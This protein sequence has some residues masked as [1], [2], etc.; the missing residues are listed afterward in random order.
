MGEGEPS[1]AMSGSVEELA[2]L[3]RGLEAGGIYNGAKLVRAL[4]EREMV[5]A[6]A[7]A[8]PVDASELGGRLDRLAGDLETSGDDAALVVSLRAAARAAE[9]GSTLPLAD[10]PRVWTCRGCGRIE[11]I[12]AP[13]ACP[14]CG[15]PSAMFR[16]HLP[17]WYLE[18]MR[19]EAALAGLG[20][21]LGAVAAA[22]AG[23]DDETLARP[24][25]PGEWS[26]REVLQHLVAAEELLATRVPRLLDEGDPELVAAAAWVL[27]PSDEAT[28][29]SDLPASA[30]LARHRLLR[31]MTLDRLRGLDATGWERAGR[32]PEWGS[33]TVLDQA[34]YFTRH[35]WSHLA[36]LQAAADGRVP[37]RPG[38]S[39]PPG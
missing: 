15:S 9:A 8:A 25:A 16:E 21:G 22:V 10:A 23:R 35:L 14:A 29:A 7:A 17:I 28:S 39:T 3:V 36:Q 31:E 6:G 34:A 12:E 1:G 26:A 4:L 24:P 18:P 38:A 32:H 37:G 33:V 13:G 2:G 30:L 11:L 19:P 20:A 5:R 27:P